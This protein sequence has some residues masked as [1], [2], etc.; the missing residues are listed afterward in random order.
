MTFDATKLVVGKKYRRRDGLVVEFIRQFNNLC[1]EP[2]L[3]FFT[4][5][6]DGTQTPSTNLIDGRGSSDGS[7]PQSDVLSDEPIK[8]PV[9]V[10][11]HHRFVNVYPNGNLCPYP[12]IEEANEAASC[13]RIG[14]YEMPEKILVTPK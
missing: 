8:E 10:T 4:T 1:H 12:T 14:V 2:R 11:N 7:Y 13:N 6:P 9:E 5:F 3:L